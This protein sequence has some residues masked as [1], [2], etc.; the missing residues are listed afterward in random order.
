M[1]DLGIQSKNPVNDGCLYSVIFYQEEIKKIWDSTISI[2]KLIPKEFGRGFQVKTGI[3][4]TS[5]KL[6]RLW[7]LVG[8]K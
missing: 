7:P 5:L 6:K 2:K 1:R 4:G 8:M 3:N